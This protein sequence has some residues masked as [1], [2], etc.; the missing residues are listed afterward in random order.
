MVG[1]G[2][3]EGGGR[4]H[5]HWGAGPAASMSQGGTVGQLTRPHFRV[6]SRDTAG[7]RQD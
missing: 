5:A 4:G 6:I 1:E 2:E 3:G 7:I